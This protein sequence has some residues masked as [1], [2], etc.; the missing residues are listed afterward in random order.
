MKQILIGAA[1]LILVIFVALFYFQRRSSGGGIMSMFQS[2]TATVNGQTY[3]IDVAKTQEEKEVGLSD[4]TQLADNQGMVF[5]FD[6]P[7][8]Y[9]FWM[10][11]M[12]FPIDIVFIRDNRIVEVY[13]NAQPPTSETESLPIYTPLEPAD[14]VLELKA[15]QADKNNLKKGDEIKVNL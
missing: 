9:S 6:N 1:I 5:T 13:P 10:K 4:K 8:Y 15:G 14:M 2:S 11:K 7:G 12:K 3:K